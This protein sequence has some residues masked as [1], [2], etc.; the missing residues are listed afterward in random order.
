[1]KKII[2]REE[3]KEK[4]RQKVTNSQP[5]FWKTT[6][7]LMGLSFQKH[8]I[9]QSFIINLLPSSLR[10]LTLT[11]IILQQELISLDLWSNACD[12]GHGETKKNMNLNYVHLNFQFLLNL[13][14]ELLC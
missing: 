10:S 8:Q 6:E 3:A 5:E 1:M 4:I 2:L 9:S 14:M 12:F 7:W 13:A 11:R